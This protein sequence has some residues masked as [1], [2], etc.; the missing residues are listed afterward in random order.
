MNPSPSNEGSGWGSINIPHQLMPEDFI[1]STNQKGVGKLVGHHPIN[2]M[3]P[4]KP[5]TNILNRES[6]FN[7]AIS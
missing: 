4:V 3:M 2:N 6:D 1:S 5:I 7:I